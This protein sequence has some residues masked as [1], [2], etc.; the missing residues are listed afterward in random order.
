MLG[1]LGLIEVIGLVP[2]IEA[3]DAALK[4]A[5]V[6]LV[7]LEKVGSGIAT[8]Q[9]S[10]DVGA[11]TAAIEA[12]G[13]VAKKLGKLR[14]THVI[15][16]L[17]PSVS[18][19][20]SPKVTPQPPKLEKSTLDIT[21]T[22]KQQLQEVVEQVKKQEPEVMSTPSGIIPEEIEKMSNKQLRQQL[23]DLGIVTASNQLSTMKKEELI[24][25]LTKFYSEGG[26]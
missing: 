8:V 19:M 24:K 22:Q 21:S 26:R 20:L 4:A 5:N 9:I 25:M 10:G 3:A 15:P 13:E 16:R 2:A 7:G 17:A 1:T 23:Q 12:G 6:H 18:Q 14:S 11:V